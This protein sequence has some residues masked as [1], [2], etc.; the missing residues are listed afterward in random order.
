M[1][2]LVTGGAGFIG[3]N[4]VEALLGRGDRVTVLDDLSSGRR[5]NIAPFEGNERFGFVE[6]SVTD[7]DICNEACRGMEVVFHQA[8]FV[9]VHESIR[10]P[11]VTVESNVTGMVNVLEAAHRAGVRTVVCASSTSVYGNVASL[12]VV[13]TMPPSPRSPYAASKAA[14][15]LFA[16]AYNEMYG[17]HIVG[18]RY[19]NVY[20]ER[21]DTSSHYAAVIPQ[22]IVALLGGGQVT[23][24]GD[25]EQTRDFV[26]VSDVVRANL[27]ASESSPGAGGQAYNIGTGTKTSVN[28]L[29]EILAAE[30]GSAQPPSFEPGLVGDVRDS[31]ADISK[32]REAFGYR[33]KMT[34]GEG[35]RQTI[36]WYRERMHKGTVV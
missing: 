18:L 9:N 4:V 33:P 6:G 27:K 5:E 7:P 16:R 24:F 3:S 8:A 34:L 20:G 30:I 36:R 29:Y 17:M 23:I 28:E 32:A 11:V 31:V 35:L 21:Q 19:F 2:C 22:F 13:E 25:G 26:H 14:G 12:P 10:N 15:E 1:N